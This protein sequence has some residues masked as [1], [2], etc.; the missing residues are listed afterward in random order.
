METSTRRAHWNAIYA[1]KATT[2]VSWFQEHP[3]LS[4][5][6]VGQVH[7]NWDAP[8]INVGGGASTLVDHLLEL[9]YMDVTVLDIS[10]K[11]LDTAKTRLGD[12]SNSVKWI[13]ADVTELE[14]PPDH[15]ALWHDR[16]VFH[17]L[18]D[19][20]EREQCIRTARKAL[21]P[22]GHAI[23]ATFA[24]DGPE[25]C[26][27][28]PTRRYS[29]EQLLEEFGPS[30]TLVASEREVHHTPSDAEQRF[31]YCLLKKQAP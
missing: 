13:E 6:L 29:P 31:A 5:T 14:L 19:P 22:G 11:A 10:R 23:I 12:K 16:A 27:G 7:P 4:L 17:F 9:G 26:S 21:A 24:P 15:Y 2:E 8:I 20:V 25:K 18:T 30:F 28:L 1:T 3:T